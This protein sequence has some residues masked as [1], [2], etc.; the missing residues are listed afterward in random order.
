LRHVHALARA[1]HWSERDILGLPLARR[2]SYLL[3][4]EAEQ[5]AFL[6]P[7]ARGV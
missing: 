5:D 6:M 7:S 2:L 3:L 4:L 1:Y